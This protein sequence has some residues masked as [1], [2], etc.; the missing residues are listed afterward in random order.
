M[1]PATAPSPT[2]A[3]AHQPSAIAELGDV[4]AW[5]IAPNLVVAPAGAFVHSTQA[6]A[7]DWDGTPMRFD[8][9]RKDDAIGLAI[10]RADGDVVLQPLALANQLQPD[11]SI[12]CATFPE[13]QWLSAKAQPVQGTVIQQAGGAWLA[14]LAHHPRLPG[15][16]LLVNGKVVGVEMG[17]TADAGDAIPVVSLDSLHDFLASD[18]RNDSAGSNA[19]SNATSV[20]LLLRASR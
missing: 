12:V 5:P 8:L 4:V 17:T 19:T 15:A 20:I 9:V 13:N 7:E 11:T 16:P 14:R 1:T 6:I 10:L 18:A 3:I 2:E